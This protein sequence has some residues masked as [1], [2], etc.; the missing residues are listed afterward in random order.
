[1]LTTNYVPGTPNWLDLG[2]PDI[3]AAVSFYSAVFGWTFQSSKP[4]SRRI[5]LLPARRRDGR[6]HRPADGRGRPLRL[7][8]V[9]PHPRR[10]RHGQGGGAG[11]MARC[12]SR[13]VMSSPAIAAGRLHRP[14]GWR[15]RRMAAGRCAG[16]G[17]GDGAERA[18]LDGAVHHRRGRGEGLLP[19][20]LLLEPSGHAHG[21]RPHLLRRVRT[22]RRRG[23]RHGA[24][25]HHAAPGGAP[26]GRFD[27]GVAPV[28]RG[29]RLRRHFRRGH[30]PWRDGTDPAHRCPRRRPHWPWS[31]TRPTPRSP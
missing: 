8:G 11:R 26:E 12:A 4:G 30:R 23:R 29:D 6:C 28:F 16:P 20:G 24:R 13:R 2:A 9:F 5:R 21:R 15:V 1:M 22:G 17:A 19:L 27:L 14:D 18:L 10:G 25:R 3:D 7:D 31:R